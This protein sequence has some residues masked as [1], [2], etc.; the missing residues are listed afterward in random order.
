MSPLVNPGVVL[1]VG[2]PVPMPVVLPV[3]LGDDMPLGEED[4]L[5]PVD[6]EE[7]PAELPDAPP[8]APPAPPPAPPPP[9]PPAANAQ[10]PVTARAVANM[11]VVIFMISVSLFVDAG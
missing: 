9:P 10:L 2:L 11:I 7:L 8:A 6:P 3:V 5:A 4:V 1:P